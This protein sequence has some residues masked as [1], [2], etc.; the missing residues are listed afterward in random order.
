MQ[1]LLVERATAAPS[2]CFLCG[3][4][5]G[6]MIDTG[7]RERLPWGAIYICVARCGRDLIKLLDGLTKLEG[8]QVLRERAADRRKI[9]ELQLEVTRLGRFERAIAD[10]REGIAV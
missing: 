6:Q 7:L 9:A 10:A 2:R 1:F 4:N 3:A 8:D 5:D